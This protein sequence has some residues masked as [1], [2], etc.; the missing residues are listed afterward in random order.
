MK[1]MV[2]T[3]G[4]SVLAHGLGQQ[5]RAFLYANANKREGEHAPEDRE[6]LLKIFEASR[7][8]LMEAGETK[9]RR[10]SAELNGT[11]G[12][13]SARWRTPRRREGRH[14]LPHPHGHVVGPDRGGDDP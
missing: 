8:A 1:I 13:L 7:A 11:I 10:M 14:A 4:T 3:C 5:D 9:A 2:T 12:M 6:Q